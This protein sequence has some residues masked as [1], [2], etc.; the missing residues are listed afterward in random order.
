MA[1]T[2]KQLEVY[3][4]KYKELLG[5]VKERTNL[6]MKSIQID[7]EKKKNDLVLINTIMQKEGF[8]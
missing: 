6:E 2:A 5:W 1:E 3:K 7:V 8:D 4:T